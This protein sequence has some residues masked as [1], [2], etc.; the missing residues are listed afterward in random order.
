M[1]LIVG[2]GNPGREYEKTRHN[3]GFMT[4]DKIANRLALVTYRLENQFKA[5]ITQTGGVGEDRIIFAKPRTF[6]NNSG[7][8][9]SKILNY[10]KIG[11]D[12]FIVICDDL[13]LDLGTIRIRHEGSSGGHK[14]LESIINKIGDNR[15]IRIKIGIGNNVA[16]NIPSEKYVLE[17]IPENDMKILDKSVDKSVEIVLKWIKSGEISEETIK[18]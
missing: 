2:L 4:L 15:F 6:M 17:K 9:V 10:Y 1:K 3:V 11:S 18:I 13:D 8:S 7:E 16:K 5:E 14:G 12:D